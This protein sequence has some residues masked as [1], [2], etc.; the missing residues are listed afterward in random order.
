MI[1]SAQQLGK[2]RIGGMLGRGA[3]AAAY[4]AYDTTLARDVALKILNPVLAADDAWLAR[5]RQEAR[6]LA[7]LRHGHIVTVHEIGEADG[8]LFIAM[9]LI[10]G[11][12]LNC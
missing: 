4:R 3:F 2:Y 12:D 1:D 8:R 7:S 9:K 6:A 5:F 11:P 10:E